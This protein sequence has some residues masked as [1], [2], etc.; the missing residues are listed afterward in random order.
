MRKTILC[1]FIMMTGLFL[2]SCG[3]KKD[4]KSIA[5]SAQKDGANWS[6]S[7]WRDAYKG[8]FEAAKPMMEEI[9]EIKKKAE[10]GSEEDKIKAAG[11]ILGKIEKYSELE[12]YIQQFNAAAEKS[13]IGRK[14]IAD[15]KFQ[16]E[17]MKELGLDEM[18]E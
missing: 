2:V 18:L 8:M 12:K 16:E 14:V 3:G 6:E 10:N 15:T 11:E 9:S 4:A 7:E 5:E 1:L 13:E 17:A